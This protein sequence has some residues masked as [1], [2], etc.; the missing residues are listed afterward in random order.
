ME[1]PELGRLPS[2]DFEVGDPV[3]ALVYDDYYGKVLLRPFTVMAT[4]D[5]CEVWVA[6][7]LSWPEGDARPTPVVTPDQAAY[8]ASEFETNIWPTDTDFFGMP[9]EHDGS[10]AI[11]PGMIGLPPDYY[12]GT[13]NIIMVSNVRDDNYYDS[14]YPFYIAGFYWSLYEDFFDRNIINIDAYDWANRLGPDDSPWRGPDPDRWRPHLYEGVVAHEYQHL[15]HDDNDF[16]EETWLNEGMSM[17]AEWL[18][19]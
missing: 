11:L 2:G 12:V 18:C 8:I 7:D 19:G 10:A 6:D 15:I 4:T 13:K 1:I 3:W 14:T 5:H 16:D 17:F 9:D